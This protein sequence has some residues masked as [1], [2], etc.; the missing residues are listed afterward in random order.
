MT[1]LHLITTFPPLTETFVLREIRQLR[2]TGLNVI[3]G[4]LRPL[5]RTRA[6]KDFD[7]LSKFVSGAGWFSLDMLR[8]FV[9]FGFRKPRQVLECLGI[10]SRS[11]NQPKHFLKMLYVLLSAM[12]LAYRF[13]DV[14]IDLVRADF[15][16]TEALAARFLKSLL[17]VPYGITAYTVF[18]YYNRAVLEEIVKNADFFV[19]DTHQTK[20]FLL[21]M[22]VPP[23]R[24][25]LI[26]NGISLD[27]FPLRDS[28][29]VADSPIILAAGYLNAK[30][31][32]HILLSACATLR[33]RGA[34]F[35]CVIIGDGD[36]R[37]SLTKLK[38]TLG[39]DGSVEM[40]GYV[41]FAELKSWYYRASVFVMP[42]VVAVTGET[43]GLPTVV[44]EALASG[45]PVVGTYTAGIPDVVVDGVNG[46]LVPANA[47]EPLADRIQILLEQ[48]DLRMRFASAARRTIERGFT[49]NRKVELLRDLILGQIASRKPAAQADQSSATMINVP[50]GHQ[51]RTTSETRS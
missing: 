48:K 29:A 31:G 10:T 12:R 20:E 41:T 22:G 5:H 11:F 42:S 15:L 6:T 24:V 8:G 35:K 44:I 34:R 40:L 50:A 23:E 21:A 28:Q 13:R 32:F 2:R 1:I 4:Q 43:D 9:F 25:H 19:A 49:L 27:E 30:K 45:L 16:H 17:G 39:L 7:D 36:Q 38:G 37:A 47:S 46:F 33:E 18:V 26:R 51:D 3:I 14:Q